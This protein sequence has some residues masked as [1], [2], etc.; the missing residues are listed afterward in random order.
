MYRPHNR[1]KGSYGNLG[2]EFHE[3]SCERQRFDPS[4]LNASQ[5]QPC[6]DL[7]IM[8]TITSAHIVLF[9]NRTLAEGI[10]F[11]HSE[12]FAGLYILTKVMLNGSFGSRISPRSYLAVAR[13]EVSTTFRPKS[14]YLGTLDAFALAR[15][16]QGSFA[17]RPMGK[18]LSIDVSMALARVCRTDEEVAKVCRL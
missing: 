15:L 1:D 7:K 11:W 8:C 3:L 12:R 17:R 9:H 5:S 2:K 10:H 16:D 6:S 18:I 14:G 4:T 13:S